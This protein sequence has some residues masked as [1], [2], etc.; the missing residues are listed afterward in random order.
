MLRG[1]HTGSGIVYLFVAFFFLFQPKV[2]QAI[3]YHETLPSVH[4]QFLLKSWLVN[5]FHRCEPLP[6]RQ[7]DAGQFFPSLFLR[8]RTL[9]QGISR[10]IYSLGL[11]RMA[12]LC[13]FLVFLTL[14]T[15]NL[16]LSLQPLLL[17]PSRISLAFVYVYPSPYIDINHQVWDPPN[18]IWSHFK[19]TTSAK[20]VSTQRI[21]D[22]RGIFVDTVQP[23]IA[24]TFPFGLCYLTLN[25]TCK[26]P[27]LTPHCER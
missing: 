23:T 1:K 16:R 13:L 19:M 6:C 20:S 25:E 24:V 21:W 9:N 11:E 17:M 8:Q 15:L 22:R 2:V 5:P 26:P 14:L 27:F 18:P 3:N 4:T 12:L 10:A 7:H